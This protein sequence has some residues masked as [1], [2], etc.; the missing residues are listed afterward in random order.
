M[1]I[2]LLER[3]PHLGE[4][5]AKVSVK[6][7]FG[8]NYLIPTGK[9]L[10]ATGENL[11]IFE[12]RRA[13]LEQASFQRLQ[14]AKER[15]VALEGLQLFI[16]A[17]AGEEDRLFGSIGVQDIIAAAKIAGHELSRN[18]VHLPESLR[19]LGEYEVALRLQGDEVVVN[20]RVT[21]SAA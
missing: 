5:G 8:R 20:I 1:E 21:V 19:Q 15:A 3:V 17:Q 6:A 4:L 12:A 7:G 9:A 16:K 10:L 13:A 14:K 2:I 18:E 11:A